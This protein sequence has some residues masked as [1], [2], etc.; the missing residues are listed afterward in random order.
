M[1]C[2]R[3]RREPTV[4]RA[5]LFDN[6]NTEP[7]KIREHRVQVRLAD[8][9]IVDGNSR[10]MVRRGAGAADAAIEV[11]S[12]IVSSL[13]RLLSL[14]G[15]TTRCRTR[16]SARSLS[17][18]RMP[19]AI[20][21]GTAKFRSYVGASADGSCPMS[22]RLQLLAVGLLT[23]VLAM[24]RLSLRPGDGSRT[25]RG[26]EQSL[27]ARAATVATALAEQPAL[28][29]PPSAIRNAPAAPST[30]RRSRASRS[31]TASATIGTSPTGR[32]CLGAEHRLWAGT[33]GRYVYFFISVADRDLVY[34]SRRGSSRTAIASCSPPSRARRAG[35]CSPRPRRARSALRRRAPIS[36][37]PSD[38][39]ER[40]IVGAW[41]ETPS[42]YALEIRVPLNL[43]RRGARS[44]RHRRGPTA[45][46][47][48]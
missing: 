8:Q 24:D 14:Q 40:R 17:T 44:R 15:P 45:A 7:L 6:T 35:G 47:I 4:S 18:R 27:L 22:L 48:P 39:Y 32:G 3:R 34:Q 36:F 11:G 21:R 43:A 20:Q 42:G 23:L 31:S 12:E 5:L 19:A 10:A 28:C 25:A 16:S 29:P 46:R 13:S 2:S 41:Q 33:Y 37:E 30:R 38:V 1:R 9:G 26:L